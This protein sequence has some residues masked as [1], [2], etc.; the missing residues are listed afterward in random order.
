MRV[1]YAIKVATGVIP[2]LKGEESVAVHVLVELAQRVQ[3][4]RRPLRQLA[5]AFDPEEPDLNQEKLTW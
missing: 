4:A 2:K 3:R 1:D 5:N